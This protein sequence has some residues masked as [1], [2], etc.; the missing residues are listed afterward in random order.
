ML[1]GYSMSFPNHGELRSRIM[2]MTEDQLRDCL[3][4]MH[5]LIR[6]YMVRVHLPN[7]KSFIMLSLTDVGKALGN[8]SPNTV[9]AFIRGTN[10]SGVPLSD[11][12]KARGLVGK[13]LDGLRP[14]LCDDES[15]SALSLTAGGLTTGP[16]PEYIPL[17]D[18]ILDV[19][20]ARRYCIE[21]GYERSLETKYGPGSHRSDPEWLALGRSQGGRFTPDGTLL[22]DD[23][24]EKI[25]VVARYG[26]LNNA[27]SALHEDG[28]T[29]LVRDAIRRHDGNLNAMTKCLYKNL[30]AV[31]E[32]ELPDCYGEE[33]A[34]RLLQYVAANKEILMNGGPR[35]EDYRK[36]A[37]DA[38]QP[39]IAS[40]LV[41][42]SGGGKQPAA[43]SGG[44]SAGGTSK[45][46][47]TSKSA[48]KAKSTSKSSSKAKAKAKS[49]SK[50]K[51]SSK[52]KPLASYWGNNGHG[53]AKVK[54]KSSAMAAA[55]EPRKRPA[56]ATM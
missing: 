49:A 8:V 19:S 11:G 47:S 15:A 36:D 30:R 18:D 13:H 3:G 34:G 21:Q 46:K 52:V 53:D 23:R 5:K 31:T 9:G 17:S 22:V 12:Q 48:S 32:K 28:K 6:G 7:G 44:K 45:S 4:R 26:S 39:K 40:F 33:E 2:N 54:S 29:S 24:G 1:F 20:G 55:S 56:P 38:D 50:S 51:S 16:D 43:A 41:S 27:G 10:Q 25:V 37:E 35:L 14:A 42:S